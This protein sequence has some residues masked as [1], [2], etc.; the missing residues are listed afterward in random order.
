M[1]AIERYLEFC[2]FTKGLE[3]LEHDGNYGLGRAYSHGR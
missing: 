3:S 2:L 1:D